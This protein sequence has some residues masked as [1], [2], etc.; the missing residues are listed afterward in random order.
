MSRYNQP[1]DSSLLGI[2]QTLENRIVSLER[3]Q[4][5]NVSV[6]SADDT[7]FNPTLNIWTPGSLACSVDVQTGRLRVIVSA[8]VS[9]GAQGTGT[10]ASATMSWNIADAR[11]T[12]VSIIGPS[13]TRG[14]HL[15]YSTGT[16]LQ[17]MVSFDYMHE[18]LAPGPYLVT[19]RYMS[20]STGGPTNYSTYANRIL[21]CIPY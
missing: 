15:E 5:G 8:L 9:P 13:T 4:R 16:R 12:N 3:A 18:G 10:F 21:T 20:E 2:V 19:D 14:I 11:N 7:L 17:Y 6:T 1:E